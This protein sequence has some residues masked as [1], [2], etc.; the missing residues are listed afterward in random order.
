MNNPEGLDKYNHL[1]ELYMRRTQ[2]SGHVNLKNLSRCEESILIDEDEPSILK[3]LTRQPRS[4]WLKT[5]TDFK[6]TNFY[7]ILKAVNR[8]VEI[9]THPPFPRLLLTSCLPS[10]VY[11][12]YGPC[13]QY[14]RQQSTAGGKTGIRNDRIAVVARHSIWTNM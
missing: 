14:A 3:E 11:S 2:Y 13:N 9:V 12:A 5:D 1:W 4:Q 10:N 6:T 7:I 8:V